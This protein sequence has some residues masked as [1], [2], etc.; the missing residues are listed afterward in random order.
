M[1]NIRQYIP[2]ID[3]ISSEFAEQIA[4]S[5]KK[6]KTSPDF[7]EDLSKVFL[8]C[9]ISNI[10]YCEILY[11]IHLPFFISYWFS[12]VWY[13]IRIVAYRFTGRF[14]SK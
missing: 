1:E 11:L 2:G 12:D 6:N 8:E 7:L 5:I 9:M 4:I 14:L 3:N 13:A 10:F